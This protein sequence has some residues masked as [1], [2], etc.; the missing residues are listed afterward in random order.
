MNMILF[1]SNLQVHV[2]QKVTKNAFFQTLILSILGIHNRIEII[3]I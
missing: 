1:F 3:N 2:K